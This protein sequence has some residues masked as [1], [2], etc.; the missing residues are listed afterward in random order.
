MPTWPLRS[1]G[2]PLLGSPHQAP[3][4]SPPLSGAGRAVRP[5]NGPS[6][7]TAHVRAGTN[8]SRQGGDERPTLGDLDFGR[9]L[10]TYLKGHRLLHSA[11]RI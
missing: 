2:A 6:R 1:S 10:T 7:D 8:R 11:L 5:T 9:D 3:P 4:V